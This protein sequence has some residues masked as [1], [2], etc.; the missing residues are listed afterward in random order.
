VSS[1]Q[2]TMVV[3]PPASSSGQYTL[4]V[5]D[6]VAVDAA[7]NSS[8]SATSIQQNFIPTAY[9]LTGTVGGVDITGW[10]LIKPVSVLVGSEWKNF[11]YLDT[12]GDG[13][14]EPLP[15]PGGAP[16]YLKHVVLD[17]LFNG[18]ADT[19]DSARSATFNY[20]SIDGDTSKT[21]SISA[22]LPTG[23]AASL[24]NT[25]LVD[26]QNFTNDLSEIWDAFNSATSKWGVPP[27]WT[28]Y[29]AS[30]IGGNN[31][32]IWSS[33]PGSAADFHTALR[34]NSGIVR[35]VRD[36]TNVWVVLQVI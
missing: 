14:S 35:N 32:S 16:D 4:T 13:T 10:N 23:P 27:G 3:T 33:T 34:F 6:G 31:V 9:T 28:F 30:T 18:G 11:Y 21:G 20:S 7:G 2:Y 5:S 25:I 15:G 8:M 22:K 19:T 1:T 29:T 12:S 24:D 26:N 36:D 17:N